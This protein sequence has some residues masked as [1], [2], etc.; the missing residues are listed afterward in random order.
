MVVVAQGTCARCATPA[1]GSRPLAP[2]GNVKCARW[3]PPPAA[4]ARGAHAPRHADDATGASTRP[5][6]H[7][8][9]PPRHRA[10]HRHRHRLA[11]LPATA[12]SPTGS[13]QRAAKIPRKQPPRA[14]KRSHS[15]RRA[16]GTAK[17]SAVATA[18]N[19]ETTNY[20]QLH[21]A[22]NFQQLH[23]VTTNHKQAPAP[24]L[25]LTTQEPL[26]E[27]GIDIDR[28]RGRGIRSASKCGQPA[29]ATI[30]YMLTS[31][32]GHIGFIEGCRH[33]PCNLPDDEA[34][35]ERHTGTPVTANCR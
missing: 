13:L 17:G 29:P 9:A 30:A 23:R 1:A 16:Q 28:S 3:F 27:P 35:R 19:Q 22:T 31:A 14:A 33:A 32:T 12:A 8:A 24:A 7:T 4:A 34:D 21:R 2:A 18:K 6:G 10:H 5:R 26:A 20:Q 25:A 11:P 15:Q